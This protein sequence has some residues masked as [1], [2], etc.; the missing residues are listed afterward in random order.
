MVKI[1][2]FEVGF[3]K[4]TAD[5]YVFDLKNRPDELFGKFSPYAAN[6]YYTSFKTIG[7]VQFPIKF[8]CDRAKNAK[9]VLKKWSDDSVIWDNK[10]INKFLENPNPFYSFKDLVSYYIQMKL[11]LGNSFLY[12]N[13]SPSLTKSIWKYCDSYYILPTQNV[14][15]DAK[16]I[17]PF[18]ID[19]VKD[20]VNS[21]ELLSGT[22]YGYGYKTKLV[23]D[24]IMHS[25][26]FWNFDDN[27]SL[28]SFSRLE[29]Q[30]Y[31]LANLVAVYEAR[32]VIYTKRGALGAIIGNVGD[33]TGNV[34]L[35]KEEHSL[36]EN[37]LV[38]L[39]KIKHVP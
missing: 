6:N 18:S 4:K 24:V 36:Y 38:H 30:K 14:S 37:F 25:R 32:N 15:I 2:R 26:D 39:Q 33:A 3:R 10:Q 19:N 22:G 11:I 8:I 23:P 5:G 12:A 21:Y 27:D 35:T 13:V 16:K 28:L 9:F 34:P 20:I 1:G 7:E 31:T 29:S 17:S